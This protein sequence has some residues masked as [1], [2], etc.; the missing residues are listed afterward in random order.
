MVSHHARAISFALILTSAGVS[1]AEERPPPDVTRGERFDGRA[2]DPRAA[3][4]RALWIPRIL[5]WPFRM[6]ERGLEYPVRALTEWSERHHIVRRVM[7]LITSEDGLVGVRPTLSYTAGFVPIFGGTF[8]DRRFI[9]PGTSFDLTVSGADPNIVFIQTHVRPTPERRAVEAAFEATYNRRNDQLFTG[10][11]PSTGVPNGSRYAVDAFDLDGHAQVIA[12]APVRFLFG[13]RFGLRRFGNGRL[14]GGDL[15]IEE[16]YC[17]RD[18]RAVCIPGTID[19]RLVPGFRQGTQFLRGAAAVRVDTRDSMVSP[20]SGAIVHLELQYT[21]GLG[22]SDPSSYVRL[23][24]G[25]EAAIDLWQRSR[26]LVLRATSDL[27]LPIGD[28][29][30]PFS[31]LVVLGGHEDLRGAR[32]GRYRDFSSLLL[33]AEYRWPVWMWMD[34]M[35]FADWGGVFGQRFAGFSVDAMVP[36]LGG[37]LRVR[38][39]S[40]FFLSMEGAYGFGSSNGWQF[41]FAASTEP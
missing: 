35:L 39:Y 27:L 33:S 2:R 8:F 41:F 10:V 14:I 11:G 3:R 40:Q 4:A 5:L 21:H 22:D 28:A 37:G 16:V 32:P 38:T 1:L 25:V 12:A 20:S 19:E 6:F 30:V 34:A 17:V 7:R 9:G 36:A 26:V 29:P 23:H 31:E 15:P 24:G 18:A 13:G